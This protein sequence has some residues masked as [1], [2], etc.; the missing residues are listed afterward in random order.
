MCVHVYTHKKEG[1]DESA[2]LTSV[3]VVCDM[4]GHRNLFGTDGTST[5][6]TFF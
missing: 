4:R 6:V 3:S 2:H 1:H 5:D